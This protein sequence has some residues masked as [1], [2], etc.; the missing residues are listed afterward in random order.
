[1]RLFPEEPPDLESLNLPPALGRFA[2]LQYGLV[3]VTG[4]T[5]CGKSTTL[6]ALIRR[7]LAR[8]RVHLV[9]IE[10]PVEYEHDHGGQHRR[11][12]GDRTG[13]AVASRTRCA[14]RC[15]RTPT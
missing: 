6:A 11:A 14:R 10:D 9:T 13:R 2:E 15:A 4:P 8:R 7:I 1:M 5:G 12:R 3:L